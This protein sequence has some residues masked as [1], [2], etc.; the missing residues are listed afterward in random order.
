LSTVPRWLYQAGDFFY[1]EL[2]AVGC[3]SMVDSFLKYLK[4]EKRYSAKTVLAYQADLQQFQDFLSKEFTTQTQ[5]VNHS[6]IR[7]WIVSLVESGLDATSVNRKIACL[8]SYFKFLI[9]RE[10]IDKDPMGKIKILKTKKKLPHFVQEADIVGLL[11][12]TDFGNDFDGLRDQMVLE[13]LYGTGMRLSELTGL[14]DSNINI[15]DRTLRVLGKRNKERVIP[16]TASLAELIN[17]YRKIR[18]RE[19]KQLDHSFL[20]TKNGAPLYPMMVNRIVKKYLKSAN[21]EKKSPHV[22]RHTYATHLLNKGAEINAVK[23]LLGH[24]SLAATQV[25]TH[26]SMDKLKKAFDQAHPKA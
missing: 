24:S 17:G 4:F 23:D 25:Y 22:L 21:V 26:N 18:N 16:F 15:R 2:Q 8:R 7:S 1:I 14:K 19:V 20:V 5:D 11:D 12:Q 9:K 13:L 10:A 3:S 6:L